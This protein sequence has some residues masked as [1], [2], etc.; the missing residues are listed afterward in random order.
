MW[1]HLTKP[2]FRQAVRWHRPDLQPG[3]PIHAA[4]LRRHT[5]SLGR[6]I[7]NPS[8]P[9][10]P[11]IHCASLYGES[12]VLTAQASRHTKV[13][14]IR[15]WKQRL[16]LICVTRS[17]HRDPALKSPRLT[18]PFRVQRGAAGMAQVIELHRQQRTRES[19]CQ[20]TCEAM[21]TLA[22]LNPLPRGAITV[23]N[24]APVIKFPDKPRPASHL[25][26]ARQLQ[27]VDDFS[28]KSSARIEVILV[29]PVSTHTCHA[30][31]R[32][33]GAL[34]WVGEAPRFRWAINSAT[35]LMAISG[36]V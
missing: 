18:F 23:A 5:A 24:D 32:T 19:S 4:A 31:S 9:T 7:R 6:P 10:G 34:R 25:I 13:L 15:T 8:F 12:P 33:P 21:H 2:D 36:T 29:K 14:A 30:S 22:S 28:C 16:T 1:W 17:A 35:M 20:Q 27:S 26:H 3:K 11:R